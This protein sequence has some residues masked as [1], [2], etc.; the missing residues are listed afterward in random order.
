MGRE[1]V[2]GSTTARRDGGLG[3]SRTRRCGRRD[4]VVACFWDSRLGRGNAGGRLL[5][6][7]DELRPGPRASVATMLVPRRQRRAVD[8]PQRQRGRGGTGG[9][10]G[11]VRVVVG[12]AARRMAG[13]GWMCWREMCVG[14]RMGWAGLGWWVDGWM[15]GWPRYGYMDC[16][17]YGAAYL[18]ARTWAGVGAIAA[19]SPHSL[20]ASFSARNRKVPRPTLFFFFTFFFLSF[21]L[22]SNCSTRCFVCSTN[23]RA[24]AR[25]SGREAGRPTRAAVRASVRDTASSAKPRG[26]RSTAAVLSPRVAAVQHQ[27]PSPQVPYSSSAKPRPAPC[28]ASAATLPAAQPT[29]PPPNRRT[30]RPRRPRRRCARPLPEGDEAML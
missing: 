3:A 26:R 9:G 25:G 2:G 21:L 6:A 30:A 14:G 20:P 7:K 23:R 22:E 27:V 17:R 4:G 12:W 5:S 28:P 8:C 24:T 15:S 10:G 29:G 16:T 18:A 13:R 19:R 1:H 11:L